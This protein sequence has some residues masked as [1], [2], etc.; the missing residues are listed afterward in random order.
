MSSLAMNVNNDEFGFGENS[1]QSINRGEDPGA[2]TS[3]VN[4]NP[5]VS[6]SH[7]DGLNK[8]I[9]PD[10]KSKLFQIDEKSNSV[11][12]IHD[13]DKS[14]SQNDKMPKL[15]GNSKSLR[16]DFEAW[17]N[18]RKEKSE[19]AMNSNLEESAKADQIMKLVNR[20]DAARNAVAAELAY[21][22]AKEAEYEK[23]KQTKIG[24]FAN[25]SFFMMMPFFE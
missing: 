4:G 12:R 19:H 2:F 1:Q 16:G 25:R 9:N 21:Q 20:I 11:Y 17:L 22:Q 14:Y 15:A 24:L 13:Y 18:L 7:S 23:L 10:T 8:S 5:V 6:P 3:F